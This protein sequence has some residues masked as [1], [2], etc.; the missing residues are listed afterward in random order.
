MPSSL[1]SA[2]ELLRE[3]V[4]PLLVQPL[5]ARSV[6]L[7]AGPRIF[8]AEGGQPVRVPKFG[9]FTEFFSHADI[10][11]NASPIYD[12]FK[13]ENE[14]IEEEEATFDELVLLPSDLKS[15][16]VIHRISN[17]L[18]RHSVVDVTNAIRDALVRRIA[19]TLDQVFLQGDAGTY[20]DTPTGILN[21][22][23]TTQDTKTWSVDTIYDAVGA[24]LGADSEPSA[25]IMNPAQ[26]IAARKFKS[27]ETGQYLLQPD[28]TAANRFTL[29]GYPVL[30]TRLMPANRV[31]LADWSQV[32][33]ARDLDISVAILSERYADYDQVGIRIVTRWDIGALNPAAIVD[34]TV[35]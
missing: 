33:V 14:L 34:Y 17:E 30:L 35:S 9:D 22:A 3:Q 32:A 6:V 19:L 2:P 12:A 8:T 24:S 27:T 29:V 28:P 26:F 18:A 4:V 23:G 1:A 7:R 31:L 15:I 11:S 25:W 16:K 13:G 5:E 21:F 20:P 10:V